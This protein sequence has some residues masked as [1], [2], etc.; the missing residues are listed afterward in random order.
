ML[1]RLKLN[2]SRFLV[3]RKISG[4]RT[5]V[6]AVAITIIFLVSLVGAL[7]I[8]PN[9]IYQIGLRLISPRASAAAP[10]V[11]L[12][13]NEGSGTTTAD[14]SGNNNTGTLV[15][16]VTWTTAG[17]YGKALSFNGS[18]G[19]VRIPDSPSWKENG[20]TGY[21]VSMWVKVKNV[22]GDYKVALGKGAWPSD[23]IYIY[24]FGAHWDFNIRTTNWSC[25][26]S[27]TALPYLTNVD[28][29]Y[30]HIAVSMNA[31][32]SRCHFYADGQIVSTDEFVS[33]TTV[34]AT[35]AGLN[36][37]YVGGLDGS[38]YLNADIDEVRVY[39][40]IRIW[41]AFLIMV[42]ED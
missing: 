32:A 26:G 18:S 20:L 13:F 25:G 37:L 14:A 21:T 42:S 33:G 3:S 41:G 34:F 7:T 36:N 19:V 38:H 39:S 5:R 2:A 30:H 12:G 15:G 35:G 9:K 17:K 28:N 29:T 31:S 8:F 10:V 40:E 4:W 22:S 27:S 16:G 6:I 23:D 24:K 1:K 11:A